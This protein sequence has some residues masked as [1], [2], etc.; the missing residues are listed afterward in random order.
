MTIYI[1]FYYGLGSRYSY[2][3]ASQI[4]YIE[5]R[6]DCQFIWKPLFSGKLIQLWQ[7][8]PFTE[9]HVSGQYDWTYRQLDA[10]R[11]ADYYGIPFHEPK[12]K[13]IAPELLAI[14]VLAANRYDLLINY[15]HLLFQKIFAEQIEVEVE[16]LIKLA[17]SL[18]IPEDNFREALRSPHLHL[19]LDQII[20]EAFHRG[21]FGVPT[22]FVDSE[23]FWGNDRLMLLEHYLSK[24]L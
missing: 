11:W 4:S 24:N 20:Q 2:L 9:Q 21:A 10:K 8:N 17:S 13:K 16:L 3:A 1:D 19:E 23:M 5:A 14:A 6:F 12:L 15:S 7:R 22:F 18:E